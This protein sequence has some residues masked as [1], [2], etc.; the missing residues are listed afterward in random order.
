MAEKKHAGRPPKNDGIVYTN[1]SIRIS[2]DEK[3]KLRE[4]A[5]KKN[6]SVTRLM[7]DSALRA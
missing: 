3:K 1:L 4:I 6:V 2:E 5:D 7:I